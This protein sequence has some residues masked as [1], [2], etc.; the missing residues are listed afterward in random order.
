MIRAHFMLSMLSLVLCCCDRAAFPRMRDVFKL[1]STYVHPFFCCRSLGSILVCRSPWCWGI[2]LSSGLVSSIN[3]LKMSSSLVCSLYRRGDRRT[4]L[5]FLPGVLREISAY[6][7]GRAV[8]FLQ[9]G[10]AGRGGVGCLCSCDQSAF[11]KDPITPCVVLE[12]VWGHRGHRHPFVLIVLLVDWM[13]PLSV[14]CAS[15]QSFS[16]R[17]GTARRIVSTCLLFWRHLCSKLASL[18]GVLLSVGVD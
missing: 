1:I 15:F 8:F 12:T 16:W 18:V 7:L 13:F 4:G 14:R 11:L 3:R 2:F 17:S 6:F 5:R 10:R 9:A